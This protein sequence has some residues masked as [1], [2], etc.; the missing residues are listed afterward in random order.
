LPQFK[1]SH[2]DT[3]KIYPRFSESDWNML[4]EV[5]K[6]TN[7]YRTELIREAVDKYHRE[8]L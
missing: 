1:A 5:S 3:K 2:R 4:N 6:K 8:S 7:R